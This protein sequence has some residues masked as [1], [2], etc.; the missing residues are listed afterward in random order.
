MLAAVIAPRGDL[1]AA[2]RVEM[3]IDRRLPNGR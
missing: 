2:R 1:V 3:A